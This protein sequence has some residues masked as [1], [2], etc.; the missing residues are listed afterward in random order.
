MGNKRK[1]THVC[2]C[3]I[4]MNCCISLKNVNPVSQ[5]F[6][7]PVSSCSR[8][9]MILQNE[10]FNYPCY[11]DSYLMDSWNYMDID[12]GK[13]KSRLTEE[14]LN[15]IS[16]FASDIC[17]VKKKVILQNVLISW[18]IHW[19][20]NLFIHFFFFTDSKRAEDDFLFTWWQYI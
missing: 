18:E 17:K 2:V 8:A 3:E 14:D 12:S 1:T 13:A 10:S 15:S 9:L 5:P 4:L 7:L 16:I 6:S 20:I 19:D 11:S